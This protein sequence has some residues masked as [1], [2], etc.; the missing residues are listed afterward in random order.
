MKNYKTITYG[1]DNSI[2]SERLLQHSI[3]IEGKKNLST[4]QLFSTIRNQFFQE[5]NITS[6]EQLLSPSFKDAWQ[7]VFEFDCHLAKRVELDNQ[8]IQPI[9]IKLTYIK[10][11]LKLINQELSKKGIDAKLVSLEFDKEEIKRN[12][13]FQ[14]A[15]IRESIIFTELYQL[16]KQI[17]KK[18][19]PKEFLGWSML[20]FQDIKRGLIQSHPNF[21]RIGMRGRVEYRDSKVIRTIFTIT[22]NGESKFLKPETLDALDYEIKKL[23]RRIRTFEKADYHFAEERIKYTNITIHLLNHIKSKI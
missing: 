16:Y 18:G 21:F 9:A 10:R 2:L 8:I 12:T 3:K 23:E 22:N 14:K 6:I 4:N 15:Q 7:T 19:V 5:R 13:C 17:D 20:N 11:N 1:L